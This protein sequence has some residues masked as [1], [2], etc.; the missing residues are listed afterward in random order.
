MLS[1]VCQTYEQGACQPDCAV[2]GAEMGGL[3]ALVPV[4]RVSAEGARPPLGIAMPMRAAVPESR[5]VNLPR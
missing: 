2:F 1:A 3:P 4:C 5:A